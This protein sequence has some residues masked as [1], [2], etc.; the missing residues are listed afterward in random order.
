MTI[1]ILGIACFY[2]DSSAAI[3]RDGELIAAVAEERF[4]RK[5]HTSDFPLSAIS[6]CLEVAGIAA[7]DLD[8]IAFYEKPLSKM[9]RVVFGCFDS[10]P[11]SSALF[12]KVLPVM[13][14]QH[15]KV[16]KMVRKKLGY[17][18]E[19]LFV[20][21]HLAHAASAFLMSPFDEAAILTMDG[22]GEWATTSKGVGK[23]KKITLTHELLFPHSLGLFYSALTYFTGFKVN[24]GEGKVMG[25]A[26]YGKPKYVDVIKSKLINIKDDGSFA[27]NMKY[28]S[29]NRGTKM[30]SGKFFREFGPPNRPEAPR[31]EYYDDWACSLQIVLE[32]A[33]IKLAQ[34]L[35]EETKLPRLCLAGGV[36]L[37]SVA[38]GL[39]YEKTDFKELY[40]Q[41]AAGD[42][43]TSAGAAAYVA[44]VLY[45]QPRTYWMEHPFLGPEYNESYIRDYLTRMGIKYT[46]LDKDT[47]TR[48][49]AQHLADGKIIGWYQGRMEFGP[50]ALGNRSILADPRHAEMKD[51]LNA[52]VKHRESFR[53]FAPAI[54]LERLTEYFELD[55]PSPHMLLVS[56]IKP[57]KVSVIPA[58][59]HVDNTGRGQTVSRRENELFY[60]LISDFDKITGVPVVLNTS[61]NVRGE[62]IVNR[63]SEAFACFVHTDM[64]TLY[65]G[66]CRVEKTDVDPALVERPTF[67]L[68]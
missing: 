60:D 26:P 10:W 11:L 33:V 38:N 46:F 22:V 32:E 58:V 8:A 15:L 13:L 39:I 23:G 40:I 36:A 3:Y 24:G 18:G 4:T 17:L 45:D 14:K 51:I 54:L 42:D 44:N 56:K 5:K 35:Y 64:D 29:F 49:A 25:L 27:L 53:P 48:D 12:S 52:R 62:P 61:F 2:H 7:K 9:E 68:D 67:E 6:Y 57:D 1:H 31:S 16:P 41:P 43:G 59:C 34:S 20:D 21:H 30:L 47:L 66:S 19:V 50:R 63:P 28:F 37:N 55:H 65:L